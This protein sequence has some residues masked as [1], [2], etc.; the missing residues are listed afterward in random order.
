MTFNLIEFDVPTGGGRGEGP[1]PRLSVALPNATLDAQMN[2]LFNTQYQLMGWIM[3]NNPA[4]VPCLHEMAWW[5]MMASTL[6]AGSVAFSAM[7]KELSFFSRCGWTPK[8]S[9]GGDYQYV[10]SCSLADGMRWGLTQRYASS[11]FY[12]CPWG[13]LTDE[14]VHFPIAVYFSVVSSGDMAWL[15]SVRP[16][17]DAIV[18]YFASRGLSV[19]AQ[20]AVYVSPT[21]GLADGGRHTSNW[22]DV[23]NFGHLDAYLAV[24]GVWA[25]KCLVELYSALG[26]AEAAAH[27]EAVAEQATR[28]FNTVFWDET[29]GAYRDW[30]DVQ[31]KA[32]SYFYVDIAF[33]AIISGVANA[34]QASA[35][36]T[37][38]NSRLQEIYVQYN[39]TPG[40]IWS[41]PCNLYPITDSCE[42]ATSGSKCGLGGVAFPGYE[43][44]GSFFHTPGLQFAA[45]GMAGRAGDAYDGFVAL[46]NSGFGRVRGWAQQL[47][48]G[49]HGG[50]DQLVGGDPLNTAV[51]PIWGFLRG[52][53]GI[54]P[55]LTRGLTV[56]NT[57]ADAME[58]AVW[59]MSYLGESL[60]LTVKGGATLFCNGSKLN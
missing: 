60:C 54:V 28:D 22:Y 11:G 20:Q 9:G 58:G 30:I 21:S 38:Y 57:P 59:N 17:L 48:W 5:P 24:H 16:A 19:P 8:E 32:R 42:F 2:V 13:T 50:P 56:A 3:G 4:S 31:G 6:D 40:S 29:S 23:I 44:G 18:A 27:A 25:M 33:V 35:L 10:H 52:T 55:T 53:F 12:N 36:L 51:L 34:T 46:M 26:D 39:V 37:H 14:D 45:L 49:T 1:F 41:A 7:Q 15:A 43:N 47:Y